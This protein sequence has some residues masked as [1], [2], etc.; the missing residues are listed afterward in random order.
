MIPAEKFNPSEKRTPRID[1]P[2]PFHAL[3]SLA[4]LLQ[5][6]FKPSHFNLFL[7]QNLT[8]YICNYVR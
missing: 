4:P 1:P 2:L 6:T 3:A 8:I 5:N 7:N